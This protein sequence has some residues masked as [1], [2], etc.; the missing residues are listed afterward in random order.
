MTLRSPQSGRWHVALVP[1]L[2]VETKSPREMVVVPYVKF[3]KVIFPES[4]ASIDFPSRKV[5]WNVGLGWLRPGFQISG[6]MFFWHKLSHLSWSLHWQQ[7]IDIK[8]DIWDGPPVKIMLNTGHPLAWHTLEQGGLSRKQVAHTNR[9]HVNE[10]TMKGFLI[11]GREDSKRTVNT[12]TPM[13]IAALFT[14]ARTWKQPRCPSADE[15]IRKLWYIYTMEYYSAVI[16]N[17]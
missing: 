3:I 6:P 9:T 8:T 16:G 2:A 4:V 17:I 5:S 13:F 1:K 15:W 12:C 10:A 7:F 11:D 14:I